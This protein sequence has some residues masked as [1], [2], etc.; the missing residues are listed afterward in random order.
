MEEQQKMELQRKIGQYASKYKVQIN[1]FVL[2]DEQCKLLLERLEWLDF[3]VRTQNSV[4]LYD[5][6]RESAE[7]YTKLILS[8]L[9]SPRETANNLKQ[10]HATRVE[11]EELEQR[12]VELKDKEQTL[13]KLLNSC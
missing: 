3:M 5:E 7:Y 6:R 8:T 12:L 10:S 9:E 11:I 13:I 4:L 2:S 1:L